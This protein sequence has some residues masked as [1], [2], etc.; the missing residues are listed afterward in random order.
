MD[1]RGAAMVNMLQHYQRLAKRRSEA[2]KKCACQ[3]K[4]RELQRKISKLQHI[5]MR[6]TSMGYTQT[7]EFVDTDGDT[8]KFELAPFLLYY[9]NEDCK[10]VVSRMMYEEKEKWLRISGDS[11]TSDWSVT[12]KEEEDGE[13][14]PYHLTELSSIAATP[15]DNTAMPDTDLSDFGGSCVVLASAVTTPPNSARLRRS[16]A[17]MLL[18]EEFS[19]RRRESSPPVP[20]RKT[21]EET[22]EDASQLFGFAVGDRIQATRTLTVRRMPIINEG[23][24]GVVIGPSTSKL[25]E[26]RVMVKFSSYWKHINVQICDIC[27]VLRSREGSRHWE[28]PRLDTESCYRFPP[29]HVAPSPR[30]GDDDDEEEEEDEEADSISNGILPIP[31]SLFCGGADE[32]A[33]E[34]AVQSCLSGSQCTLHSC[35]SPVAS[36]GHRTFTSGSER[37]Y[38]EAKDSDDSLDS[39]RV[40]ASPS[41][42]SPN[43]KDG[44]DELFRTCKELGSPIICKEGST[45]D[46]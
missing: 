21:A 37:D 22:I 35:A 26:P 23:E 13:R 6:K 25:P 27:K 8:N 11:M 40:V 15:F 30:R 32:N 9:V 46:L 38:Q 36:T 12:L 42:A 10:G 24:E 44:G 41:P 45:T 7:L 14:V 39:E 29:R 1:D 4:I 16:A 19:S 2:S 33:E 31:R 5:I 34:V 28:I 20:F 3:Y 18:P 17:D 43:T